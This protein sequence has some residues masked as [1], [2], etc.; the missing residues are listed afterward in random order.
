MLNAEFPMNSY[1]AAPTLLENYTILVTGAGQGLGR[2]ASI[3]YAKHGATVILLGRTVRKL[4]QVYD[5]ILAVGGPQPAIFPMDLAA[6]SDTDFAT[7]AETIGYQMGHLNG[8]LHCAA[9]FETLAPQ[10]LESVESWMKLFKVNAAAPAA[11][12]RVC[13]DILE[14]SSHTGKTSSGSVILIGETHGH[15]PAAYWGGFAVSK[16][17]LEAYFKV[18]A[19]EWSDGKI[20]INLIIPGPINSP[21]RA[22][23]HPGEVKASLPQL[24]GLIPRLL[25]LMGP[26]SAE[27]RGQVLK[28]CE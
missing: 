19:D 15:L 7:M 16:A 14:T 4:E 10:A 28:G 11:I 12:N 13:A 8:I 25:Y 1:I 20:R 3:A 5:E 22:K 18:Q 24:E 23:T 26:D 6:A 17:A 27:V 21:Q 2:A 9:A